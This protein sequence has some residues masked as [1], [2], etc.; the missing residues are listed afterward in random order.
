MRTLIKTRG[1]DVCRRVKHPLIRYNRRASTGPRPCLGAD[2]QSQ[3][4]SGG[5]SAHGDW[6]RRNR[7]VPCACC[8]PRS[9]QRAAQRRTP[10][11]TLQAVRCGSVTPKVPLSAVWIVG[12]CPWSSVRCFAVY[13]T[14]GQQAH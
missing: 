10:I 1:I 11:G 5:R 6:D 14:P 7:H 4:R 8:R 9:P 2:L 13:G 3:G 12:A